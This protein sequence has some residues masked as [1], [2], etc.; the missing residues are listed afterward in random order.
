VRF[1]ANEDAKCLKEIQQSEL[2]STLGAEEA[3]SILAAAIITLKDKV[4]WILGS[5]SDVYFLDEG[6]HVVDVIKGAVTTGRIE[7]IQ[8]L[9]IKSALYLLVSSNEEGKIF[10]YSMQPLLSKLMASSPSLA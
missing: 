5:A 4:L 1:E 10:I 6:Y 8:V 2:S 9:D 7:Q 3:V